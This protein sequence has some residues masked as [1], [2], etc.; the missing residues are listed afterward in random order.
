M[1]RVDDLLKLF[2]QILQSKLLSC[3]IK[4]VFVPIKSIS[5]TQIKHFVL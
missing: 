3:G 5:V 1:D 2:P 4:G